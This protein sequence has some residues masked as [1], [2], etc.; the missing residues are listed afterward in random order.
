MIQPPIPKGASL[1]LQLLGLHPLDLPRLVL[2]FHFP[3]LPY[4][5]ETGGDFFVVQPFRCSAQ[6]VGQA[7]RGF[8]FF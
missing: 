4:G 6:A 1:A 2:P 7:L 8:P 5:C 3:A